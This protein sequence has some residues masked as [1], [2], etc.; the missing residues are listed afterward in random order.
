MKRPTNTAEQLA[1]FVS[2]AGLLLI[3]EGAVRI[4]Q[5]PQFILPAPSQVISA[6]YH[7]RNLLLYHTGVTLGE[8]LG[9]LLLAIAIAFLMALLLHNINWL[10]GMIYPLL[11]LSQTIPLVILA[12]L[13]PLWLGWGIAPKIVIVVLVCFFPIVINLLN[14]LDE[15]DPDQ[16]SLFHSMGAS[17]LATFF[18]V[19]MPA[20]LPAFFTGIRISATYSLMAAV[21][22]EWVGAQRGLGYFMT[23]KQKAFAI[24]EVLAAVLVICLLSYL[25]VKC[26]DGLEYWLVPWNRPNLPEEEWN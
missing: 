24:D 22:S 18:M 19:K 16:L 9:G 8:A 10:Y 11:I 5:V 1:P 25:L 21:I 17:P 23:I 3:W 14:G 4:F 26:T 13:L 6:G 7:I 20:A 2:I 15:V 12:I